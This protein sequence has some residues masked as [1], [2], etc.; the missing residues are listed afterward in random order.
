M[1]STQRIQGLL[2]KHYILLIDYLNNGDLPK[3]QLLCLFH[4]T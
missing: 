3:K 1:L 2:S 4:L